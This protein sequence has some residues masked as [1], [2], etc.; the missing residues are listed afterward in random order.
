MPLEE[1]TTCT[2]VMSSKQWINKIVFPCMFHSCNGIL[3][4]HK[5]EK[6]LTYNSLEGSQRLHTV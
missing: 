3:L 1:G 6:L 2:N 5:K 4:N